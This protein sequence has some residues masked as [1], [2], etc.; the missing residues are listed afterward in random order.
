MVCFYFFVDFVRSKSSLKLVKNTKIC[1]SFRSFYSMNN[2]TNNS[3]WNRTTFRIAHNSRNDLS[4]DLYTYRPSLTSHLHIIEFMIFVINKIF[5]IFLKYAGFFFFH[6]Q[7]KTRITKIRPN[8]S[9]LLCVVRTV[10][11]SATSGFG[12]RLRIFFAAAHGYS[13]QDHAVIYPEHNIIIP[14]P[15]PTVRF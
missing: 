6:R 12:W 14:V 4:L 10:A 13:S 11:R 8:F 5:L 9:L 2:F 1:Y 7:R 3:C 15:L